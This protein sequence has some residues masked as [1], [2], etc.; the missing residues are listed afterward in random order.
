MNEESSTAVPK[1]FYWIAGGAIVWNLFG[2]LAYIGQVS[3]S[4]EAIAQLP[5]DQ[6]QI[7]ET[8]PVWAT[9]AY[10]IAVTMGVLG[11]VL[12]ILRKAWALPVFIVSLL[13]VIVQFS[14]A[15][16]MTDLIAVT[17][18]ASIGFSVVIIV[19][20]I[21]LIWYSFYARKN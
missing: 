8:I 6:Q 18:I 4:P 21:L 3:M 10:A 1:S 5:L 16:F 13:G 9:S 12:L 11:R 7:Y 15:V 19:I 17:G 14:H 20:A 2:M